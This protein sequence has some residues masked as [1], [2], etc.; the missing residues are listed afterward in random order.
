MAS[1]LSV[2]DISN[3][4]GVSLS[5]VYRVKSRSS[6]SAGLGR[7][8]GSGRPPKLRLSIQRSIAQQIKCKP[9]LSLRTLAHLAPGTPSH[10]TVRRALKRL[11][12]KKKYPA[13]PP[14]VSERNRTYRVQ[15]ARKFK[16]PKKL[17]YQ[18]I[19]AD[20]MSIWLSRGKIKMW[21][22]SDKTRIVRTTKH[23]PK[24]NVWAAFSAMGTF[25]LCI[26]TENMNSEMFIR[27]LEGH[28]LSQAEVF[29]Q[30]QWRLAMDDDPKHTSKIAKEFLRRNVPNELPWPSQ[31]PDLNPIENL[32]GWVKQE[33][34]KKGPRTISE[35]KKELKQLWEDINPD[36]LQPYLNS[37]P[38]RCQLVI[39][40]IMVHVPELL[41][42][43]CLEESR[44]VELQ[45]TSNFGPGLDSIFQNRIIA[46]FINQTGIW[47][48]VV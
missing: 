13:N 18:T 14:L 17:W 27:I 9:Y 28:L 46:Q 30:D 4:L 36:F 37:M 20:E 38:H 11:D 33:L 34:L 26:F 35:L 3:S 22:K 32:F 16:Y 15:W 48:V 40:L 43:K 1:Y 45:A 44:V 5:T 47:A 21:T 24:I 10:E 7:K 25:P 6:N 12:Y 29:H 8:K 19:F 41:S 23:V 31:S 2:Q 39:E 42:E